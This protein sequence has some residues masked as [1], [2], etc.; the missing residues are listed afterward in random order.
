MSTLVFLEPNKIDAEPFTTSDVVAEFA[1]VQHHAIQQIISKYESDFKEFGTVAFEM[2]VCQHRTGATTQKIYH[3]NEEQATLL[4]TY[5]KNT[6]TVRAFKKEL[7]RQ[8]C[9]MRAE[10]MKRQMYRQE[11]KPI[12]RELTDVIKEVDDGRWSY[13][14]YTDLAYKSSVG[15]NAAQLRKE[16]NAPKKAVAV[17]YMTS[18]EI[19]AVSKRQ[20]Q[21]AVLLELG[22][23]YG[24]VKAVV[25]EHKL[26]GVI[27]GVATGQDSA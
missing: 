2:R 3:L 12:R 24:Q 8:F 7:V 9:A 27:T 26:V 20:S 11:L 13:K 1:G 10:L 22:M 6:E 15:K 19:A 25:L 16:R 4:I 5:L 14:K 18:D 23:D 17:D 21:I